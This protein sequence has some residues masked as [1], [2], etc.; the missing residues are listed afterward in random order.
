[1]EHLQILSPQKTRTPELLTLENSNPRAFNPKTPTLV[2]VA[3]SPFYSPSFL[4]IKERPKAF[5]WP[6]RLCSEAAFQSFR[7]QRVLNRLTS[8]CCF[9]SQSTLASFRRF[10]VFSF[11]TVLVRLEGKKGSFDPCLC[12]VPSLVSSAR[13]SPNFFRFQSKASVDPFSVFL[14]YFF[15]FFF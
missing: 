8:F 2:S 7:L 9:L 3:S 11:L 6:R 13:A 15:L 5:V 12:S 4:L 10:R 14:Y 1:M